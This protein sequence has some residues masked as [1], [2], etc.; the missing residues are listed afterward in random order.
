MRKSLFRKYLCVTMAILLISYIILGSITTTLFTRYWTSES[1]DT[2]KSNATS[3]AS[4]CSEFTSYDEQTNQYTIN[5]NAT[6]ALTDIL[7][8]NMDAD[9][10]VTDRDGKRLLG[11]YSCS[12][13]D[14]STLGNVDQNLVSDAMS[15]YT[16]F[17]S[18]FGDSYSKE[19]L[20]IGVPLMVTDSDGNQQVAGAVF[21][22]TI[23]KSF[24]NYKEDTVKI[25]VLAALITFAI[26]FFFVWAFTYKMVKPLRLMSQA[27]KAFGNGDFSIRVP[28]DRDDEI[29]E[30]GHAF[31][32]MANS[33]SDSEGMRR[34]FIANV[35]H[36]LKTPMTTISGFIDG[37]LD[38]TIP[39]ERQNYY[40]KIVSDETKR[41]SRLV[42][43]MLN[44]S[45]IDAGE[46]RINP[47][48]FDITDTVF[49]TILTFEQKIDEKQIE[50]RNLENASPLTV[51]GDQDLLHQVIYNI[52]EN[53]VKFTNQGGYISITL[54]DS[55]DR[56]C[57]SIE[58]SGMGIAAEDVP[59]VFDRFYKT[60]K[61]RSKDKN[62]LGLG[63]FLCKTILQ[64][65]GGDITCSSVENEYCRFDMYIPKPANNQKN[66][67]K[68]INL[69]NSVDD[70]DI[71][72][73]DV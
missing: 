26:S 8:D 4:F 59:R 58:N 36:E 64:L 46:L 62:G 61:S 27:A 45:R 3:V 13:V 15:G 48:K 65:H 11:V 19:Y 34:S 16:E 24:T 70:D 5:L 21:A 71:Q 47:V 66:P 55:I 1:R 23:S 20:T 10:F 56:A 30:L 6:K 73:V 28:D 67:D 9:I 37:I 25:F 53:A 29:G 51:Y 44:L 2:L 60:D 38:G 40:L 42:H 52:I 57:L 68:V 63:L 69:S 18:N 43:S 22:A 72:D 39:P 7:S 35:S 54:S 31:N 12:G 32:N 17:K 41:L 50:I 14:S 49:Q 33:L